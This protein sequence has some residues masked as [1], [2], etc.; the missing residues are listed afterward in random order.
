[1]LDEAEAAAPD[2][3]GDGGDGGGTGTRCAAKR[4]RRRKGHNGEAVGERALP[5]EIR[6]G[7]HRYSERRKKIRNLHNYPFSVSTSIKG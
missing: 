2:E 5:S 4:T 3:R 1:M 7:R 6:K